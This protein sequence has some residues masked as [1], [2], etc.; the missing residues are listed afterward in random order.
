MPGA[1][2]WAVF[3][4]LTLLLLGISS[5]Y[6]MLDVIVTFIQDRWHAKIKRIYLTTALCLVAW[7][8]SFMYST[9]AGYYILDGVDRWINNMTLVFVVWSECAL[10]TSVYRYKDIVEECGRPAY[11]VYCFGYFA[12]QMIAVGVG[13]ATDSPGAGAGAGFGIFFAFGAAAVLM[14][15][16]PVAKAPSF[17]NKSTLLRKL[18]FLAFYSVSFL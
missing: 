13:H 12:S 4:F 2:F 7:L 14:A 18:W 5:T 11:L 3:F 10:S 6:P 17:F 16:A 1:N 8:I 15:K 9:R